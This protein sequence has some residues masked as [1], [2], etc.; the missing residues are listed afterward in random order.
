MNAVKIIRTLFKEFASVTDE[1]LGAYLETF[2]PMLSRKRFGDKY[3]LALAYYTA[4]KMSM[5]G[6]GEMSENLLG[7]TVSA[8]EAAALSAAGVASVKDGE[9]AISF[10]AG[11]GSAGSGNSGTD[12]EY[13]KTV[14]GVQ[15]MA[16]RDSCIVPITIA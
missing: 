12:A 13:R 11:N 6:L 3:D 8:T 10:A 16:I 9:T 14:Y 7:G 2:S 15:Y 5:N 1:D 4:H